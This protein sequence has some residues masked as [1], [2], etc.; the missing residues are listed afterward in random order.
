MSAPR[1]WSESRGQHIDLADMVDRNL[2]SAWLKLKRGEYRNEGEELEPVALALLE[3]AFRA[4][5]K[6]RGLDEDGNAPEP[7]P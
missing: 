3:D 5:F 6:R 4:E 7:Q 1:W 2:R